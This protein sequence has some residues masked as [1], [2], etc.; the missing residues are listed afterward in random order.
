MTQTCGHLFEKTY[1]L[2]ALH[3]AVVFFW[4]GGHVRGKRFFQMTGM[5]PFNVSP[6]RIHNVPRAWSGPQ[7]R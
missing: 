6:P 7:G 2:S 1:L 3:G 4:G 5:G